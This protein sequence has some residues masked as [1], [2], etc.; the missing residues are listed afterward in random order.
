MR[1]V[2]TTNKGYTLTSKIRISSDY[3][4]S[5]DCIGNTFG[6]GD[7]GFGIGS[8][9]GVIRVV[10]HVR[11]FGKDFIP[12]LTKALR[13][14]QISPAVECGDLFYCEYWRHSGTESLLSSAFNRLTG[15]NCTRRQNFRQSWSYVITG[16]N[17]KH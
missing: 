5:S 8:M 17:S 13:S 1:R 6:G 12:A 2:T 16:I 4:A 9:G 10:S 7:G 3:L 14:Q 11:V 15:D